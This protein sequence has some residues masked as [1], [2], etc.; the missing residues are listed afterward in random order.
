[1]KIFPDEQNYAHSTEHG[2]VDPLIL[3]TEKGKRVIKVSF[4]LLAA[5]TS[6]QMAIALISVSSAVLACTFH[7]LC[8]AVTAIPLWI[9]FS[10]AN[11]NPIKRFTYGYV[12]ADDVGGLAIVFLILVSAMF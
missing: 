1:M 2:T 3:S 6:L 11:R 9:A 5:I 4:M 8:D 10:I 7:S 12:R